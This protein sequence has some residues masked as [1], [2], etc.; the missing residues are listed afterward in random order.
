MKPGAA[1]CGYI[2]HKLGN[3]GKEGGAHGMVWAKGI[4]LGIWAVSSMDM[5]FRSLNPK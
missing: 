4:R 2:S 3:E 5:D 1:G